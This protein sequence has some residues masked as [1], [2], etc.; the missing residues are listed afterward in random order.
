MPREDLVELQE[1]ISQLSELNALYLTKNSEL[2]KTLAQKEVQI[3]DKD[4]QISKLLGRL[5]AYEKSDFSVSM[6]YVGLEQE[7]TKVYIKE[8]L[9]LKVLPYEAAETINLIPAKSVVDVLEKVYTEISE[10]TGEL[11]YWY[12]VILQVYD[13]P[14][15][16]RGWIQV[17]DSEVYEPGF[18][19]E[20]LSP[21]TIH[22]G[23]DTYKYF[24]AINS[25]DEATVL[26]VSTLG[27]ITDQ[28][29]DYVLVTIGGGRS[30][31][32]L[33]SNI[34]YPEPSH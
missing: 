25:P 7:N 10:E 14:T 6:S 3:K 15:N 27:M 29:E 18:K 23:A 5:E 11:I 12:Y 4:D 30:F 13:A 31:W 32:T 19:G 17:R 1:E 33:H 22:K 28:K 21:I 24:D 8:D 26:E 2:E 9:A 16:N 34:T 20:I